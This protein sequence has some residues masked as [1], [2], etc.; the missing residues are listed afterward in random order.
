[1]RIDLLGKKKFGF[2]TGACNK[3]SY[4][5][6]LHE[7]WETCNAI[8]LSWIM[9]TVSERY[10]IVYATNACA[11]WEDLKERVFGCL[12]YVTILARGDKFTER[13]KPIVLEGYFESEKGYLLLDITSKKLSVS[14]DVVIHEDTFPFS[15]SPAQ[16]KQAFSSVKNITEYSLIPTDEEILHETNTKSVIEVAPI[17]EGGISNAA[18]LGTASPSTNHKETRQDEYSPHQP[19][20]SRPIRTSRPPV[21]MHDYVDT[22]RNQRCKYP[23]A[24]N[25]S[26]K[27]LSPTYQCYLTKFSTLIEPQHY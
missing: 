27:N 6:E 21:W 25:L 16:N 22:S 11:V 7:Q 12:C 13:A 9:N 10:G 5:E 18:V 15:S 24:N 19:S 1:M 8:V 23:L 26:Y 3:E 4:R 14:R 17:E 20:S 2:F